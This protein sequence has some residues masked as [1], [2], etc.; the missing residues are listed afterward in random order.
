MLAKVGKVLEFIGML[1]LLFGII[2]PIK[3][4]IEVV[5]DIFSD[6]AG[7]GEEKKA[8]VLDALS[9]A[10]DV[11][12]DALKWQVPKETLLGFASVIIDLLVSLFNLVG[13][14]WHRSDSPAGK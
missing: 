13:K 10:I 12:E 7:M 14:F 5:E 2:A 8:F 11:L 9:R 1:R 3:D 4:L 6:T